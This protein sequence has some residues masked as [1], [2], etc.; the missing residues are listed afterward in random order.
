MPPARRGRYEQLHS[1]GTN[2]FNNYTHAYTHACFCT[3]NLSV[4]RVFIFKAQGFEPLTGLFGVRQHGGPRPPSIIQKIPAQAAYTEAL[5]PGSG[6]GLLQT[7]SLWN[8]KQKGDS[9]SPKVGVVSLVLP[10]SGPGP[11]LEQAKDRDP[12]PVIPRWDSRS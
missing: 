5:L 6:S 10:W 7:R 12:T 3:V 11:G 8:M 1:R 4:C 2:K 9:S